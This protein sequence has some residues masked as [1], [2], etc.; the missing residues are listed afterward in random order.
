MGFARLVGGQFDVIGAERLLQLGGEEA[1]RLRC[2][3][4][5][6]DP[7]ILADKLASLSHGTGLHRSGR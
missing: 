2:Q 3:I 4:R 5:V 6:V 1:V 7:D